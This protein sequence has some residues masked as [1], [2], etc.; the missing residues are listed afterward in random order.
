MLQL[1]LLVNYKGE[2][3]KLPMRWAEYSYRLSDSN[4]IQ[5]KIRVIQMTESHK[6]KSTLTGEAEPGGKENNSRVIDIVLLVAWLSLR[7]GSF[8]FYKQSNGVPG[9][10]GGSQHPSPQIVLCRV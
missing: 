2:R 7:R 4:M 5:G 8:V 9:S 10:H 1:E 6:L 3:I